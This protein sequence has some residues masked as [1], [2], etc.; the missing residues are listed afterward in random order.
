MKSPPHRRLSWG[1]LGVLSLIALLVVGLL[2]ACGGGDSSSSATP[3]SAATPP[4]STSAAN[5]ATAIPS[6][7]AVPVEGK[8]TVFAAASLTDAFKELGT[9]FS[10]ANPKASVTFNFASS[11]A[12][13]TQINEGAPA[14]VFASADLVQMKVVTDKGTTDPQLIFATNVPVVVVP[15]SG[16]PVAA[17]EDL[18][19]SGV[20]LV[21]AAPAV[22]IGNYARQ[23]FAN[24][25]TASGAGA[26]FATKVL[27]NLKS[28][29]A[30]VKSVLVKIQTGEG[31]A[32]VVYKTDAAVAGNQVR[33]LV[34]P[35]KYNV[36]AQ[37]PIAAIKAS[38]NV[39]A[40]RAFVAFL[41]SNAGQ[42]IM[43]KYGF[44]KP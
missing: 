37:Y 27:A 33:T 23:I 29:E 3:A 35:D 36:I 41:T 43:A 24:A 18:A 30:D 20:K 13:A 17:F 5:Q 34:I 39:A 32:G 21:L 12:L 2:S 7:T 28:N 11:S 6:P 31:D 38:S 10:A 4:P 15:A 1:L 14:D 25:S 19:K 16:S 42:T 22:P 8:I 26:D 40:A 9:A 44:G